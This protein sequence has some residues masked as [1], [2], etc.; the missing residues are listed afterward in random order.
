[1]DSKNILIKDLI[2]ENVARNI[3]TTQLRKYCKT[4]F[5]DI[6][7]LHKGKNK[8]A[9]YKIM[10]TIDKETLIKDCEKYL[11]LVKEGKTTK[12]SKSCVKSCNMIIK[13]LS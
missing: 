10:L 13:K 8:R 2:P 3:F 11:A 7:I 6:T 1:M 4:D 5:K 12:L 9:V